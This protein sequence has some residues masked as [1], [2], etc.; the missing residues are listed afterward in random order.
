MSP[1][2]VAL[3]LGF[4]LAFVGSVPMSGPVAV[5]FLARLLNAERLA[6]LLVAL[7][8][9]VVEAGY[10]FGVASLLPRLVGRTHVVVLVSLALGSVVVTTLG[11]V[12]F[13]R[14]NILHQAADTSA[15]RGFLRGAL[16][17]LFNPTLIATWTVAV[18]TLYA[19]GW[20]SKHVSSAA[21][22]AFGV[23]LGSLTWFATLLAITKARPF[24]V[25]PT[26]RTKLLRA[27]GSL[28]VLSGLFLAARFIV[29][30]RH[31]ERHEER[32]LE[33][34]GHLL[35]ELSHRHGER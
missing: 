19:N 24:H 23:A 32:G 14:P 12:L 27:M 29:Q 1:L 25:T 6:A 13:A 28:L 5:L 8:G 26:L 11:A 31:P 33:R 20:L 16:S 15:R 3:L 34:A 7:G 2:L 17:S 4:G 9:A 18:S 21:G 10:A 30:L 22:L 35:D